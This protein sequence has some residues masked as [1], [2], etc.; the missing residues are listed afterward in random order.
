L[1]DIFNFDEI[2]RYLITCVFA[3]EVPEKPVTGF[4]DP[5]GSS[6]TVSLGVPENP[7]AAFLVSSNPLPIQIDP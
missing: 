2:G 5:P 1:N 3:I 4:V 6:A 7:L